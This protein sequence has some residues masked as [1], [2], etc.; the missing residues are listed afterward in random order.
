MKQVSIIMPVFNRIDNSKKCLK[1]LFLKLTAYNENSKNLC[2]FSVVVVDDGSTDGTYE[3]ISSHYPCI[4]L[5]KG[6]GNLWWSGAINLGAH[7]AINKLNADFLLL[8]DNDIIPEQN[9]FNELEKT[10]SKLK[11]NEICGSKIFYLNNFNKVWSNGGYFNRL[12]GNYGMYKKNI[13]NRDSFFCE[14]DWLPGMGTLIPTNILLELKVKWDSK[15]FPQYH[16][17]ADFTLRAKKKGCKI[18][19]NKKLK[20]FNDTESTGIVNPKNT[21]EFF[22][23]LFSIKSNYNILKNIVFYSRHGFIPIVYFGL[24]IKYVIYLLSAVKNGKK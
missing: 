24:F 19:I 7:Y 18:I 3:F 23:F 14:C 21:R 16:G 6:N 4:D 8:W 13:H 12:F 15:T 22:Q 17:D 2:E 5:L 20:I 1:S 10:I 9:Y 11:S